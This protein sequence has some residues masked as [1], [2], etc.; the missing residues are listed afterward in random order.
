MKSSIDIW[1]DKLWNHFEQYIHSDKLFYL[2]ADESLIEKIAYDIDPN[3]SSEIVARSF[4]I[5]CRSLFSYK[6]AAE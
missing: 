2:N 3:Q 4:Y 1:R 5:E 6:N